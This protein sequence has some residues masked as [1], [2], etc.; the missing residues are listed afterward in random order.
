MGIRLIEIARAPAA[1]GVC[2]LWLFIGAAEDRPRA[3]GITGRL[4][5]AQRSDPAQDTVG[6]PPGSAP[7]CDRTQALA[8]QST[9]DA[10]RIKQRLALDQERHRADALARQLTTLRTELDA[11]RTAGKEAVQAIELG[12]KQTQAL[13][14][15]RDK[16]NHLAGELTFVR[17]E[18]DMARIAASKGGPASEVEIKQGEAIE[19][20]RGRAE[21]LA[22]ELSTLKAELDAARIAGPETAKS[23]PA[24]VEQKQALA[25]E[26]GKAENL[27]REVAALRVEL[28][29]ARST[30]SDAKKATAAGAEQ[31]LALEREL[32]QQQDNTAALVR[33]L[34][35]R[36]AELDAARATAS[37]AAQATAAGAEQ[38]QALERELKQE[39]DKQETLASELA[40][41]RVEFDAARVAA[42][43]IADAA[44]TEQ[45]QA[46]NKDRDRAETL[47]REL[48]S[49]RKQADDRSS[50]LAAAHAEILQLTETNQAITAEQQKAIA[51]ERERTG[52]LARELASVKDQLT[53]KTQQLDTLNASLAVT[54]REPDVNNQP[55]RVTELCS[56]IAQEK[57]QSPEQNPAR[58]AASN[59]ER[60]SAPQL[61]SS[62]IRTTA[63]KPEV[64]SD[65]KVIAVSERPAS[66][67]APR[68]PADEQRLLARANALLRQADISSARSLLEHALERGSAR[69]AFMLA[70]TYDARVLQSWNARGIPADPAKARELYEKAQAGGIDDAKER[71]KTLR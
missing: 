26:R 50:R 44:S 39:R 22:R 57:G 70:E 49:A 43:Q 11:A 8:M 35:S 51:G 29:T 5:L 10:E 7:A 71:L 16:T 40:S 20:E 4:I 13:E 59:S 46:F 66:I 31:K 32:K 24:E 15:E 52:A 14:Q 28:D 41:L 65:P 1:V 33:D 67:P 54:A 61:L 19:R 53:A 12:I 42:A 2:V 56:T 36:Q 3:E 64:D 47:A 62:E 55:A 60:S 45:K 37:E 9:A 17:A 25:E 27:A 18:L 38:K 58:P 34:T 30:A 23:S 21:A 48:T 68:S 69:A 6:Q 63:R